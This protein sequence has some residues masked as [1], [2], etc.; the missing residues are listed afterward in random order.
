MWYS[1]LLKEKIDFEAKNAMM[2][3]NED[4]AQEQIL[5]DMI[6]TSPGDRIPTYS[7]V[8]D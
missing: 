1:E 7:N 6:T 2:Q 5:H 8:Q 3:D 4:C